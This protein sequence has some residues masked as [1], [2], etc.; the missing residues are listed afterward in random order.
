VVA[1]FVLGAGVTVV[2]SALAQGRAQRLYEAVLLKTLGA[3]RGRIGRA[4][5]VEYGVLGL[6][7]GLGGTALGAALAWVVLRV[8]LDMPWRAEPAVLAGGVA[9]AVLVAVGVGFLGSARLLA[10]RP[11]P[12]LRGE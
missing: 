4:F 2:A 8:L 11:L 10:R 12:V 1:L 7:A 6:V 9:L 5:A 3:T